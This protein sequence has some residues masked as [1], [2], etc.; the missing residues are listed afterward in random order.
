MKELDILR[1]RS[2]RGVHNKRPCRLAK[3]DTVSRP[4]K[5]WEMD[6]KY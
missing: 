3:R 2:Q 6:L 4:N 1:L 5:L